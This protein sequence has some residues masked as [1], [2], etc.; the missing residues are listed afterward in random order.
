MLFVFI[1]SYF[2]SYHLCSANIGDLTLELV[3]VVSITK[4]QRI[5]T[6]CTYSRLRYDYNIYY[7]DRFLDMELVHQVRQ[8]L[9]GLMRRIHRFIGPKATIS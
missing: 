2:L 8:K 6:K 4:F 3:Q 1:I 7:Y 9:L 5:E